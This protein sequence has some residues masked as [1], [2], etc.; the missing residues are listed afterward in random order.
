MIRN[1]Y[2]GLVELC[3]L[4]KGTGVYIHVGQGESK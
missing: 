3:F 1:K 2:I 4:L